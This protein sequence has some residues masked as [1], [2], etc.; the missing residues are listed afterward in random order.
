MKKDKGVGKKEEYN[1]IPLIN[2]SPLKKI[3]N[4]A[5][6]IKKELAGLHETV[7]HCE[8]ALSRAYE[9]IETC[10]EEL[11]RLSQNDLFTPAVD[12]NIREEY[13][14]ELKIDEKL[15]EESEVLDFLRQRFGAPVAI[16]IAQEFG[17]EMIYIPKRLLIKNNHDLIRREYRDGASYKQLANKYGY[18]ICHIR[19][20]IHRRKTVNG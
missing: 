14:K 17:G 10:Q 11:I 9:E 4:L 1:Q 8:A 20:I 6:C 19:R 12:E 2:E 16:G 18:G 5:A 3:E 15:F 13:P 7:R